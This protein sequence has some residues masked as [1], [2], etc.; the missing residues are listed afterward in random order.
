MDGKYQIRTGNGKRLQWNASWFLSM[1]ERFI[2]GEA[3]GDEVP[4]L[5]D[6]QGAPLEFQIIR[7][8]LTINVVGHHFATLLRICP[9]VPVFGTLYAAMVMRDAYLVIHALSLLSVAQRAA[10]VPATSSATW[11]AEPC[12]WG[13]LWM[14]V[15][16]TYWPRLVHVGLGDLGNLLGRVFANCDL[17]RAHEITFYE[18]WTHANP[19]QSVLDNICASRLA[20]MP[21]VSPR[22][23]HEWMKQLQFQM[24][25]EAR[26]RILLVDRSIG[27]H[28]SDADIPSR[29]ATGYGVDSALLDMLWAP[30]NFPAYC[31]FWHR[32]SGPCCRVGAAP[33]T[34]PSL[35]RC[36]EFCCRSRCWGCMRNGSFWQA[37]PTCS[38]LRP[39][40]EMTGSSLVLRCKEFGVY[41]G[42][43]LRSTAI[44]LTRTGSRQMVYGFDSFQGLVE[45]W[46]DFTAFEFS[47]NGQL[48]DLPQNAKL[49]VGWYNETL[50]RFVKEYMVETKRVIEWLHLDC[51]TFLGHHQVCFDQ[52][53]L[54]RKP[55]LV[56]G[57]T[58]IFDDILNYPG[59]EDH[60]LRAFYN[61]I[62]ESQCGIRWEDTGWSF[63]VLSSPWKVDWKISSRDSAHPWWLVRMRAL[64]VRLVSA[65]GKGS[66]RR[67]CDERNSCSSAMTNID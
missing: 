54:I 6:S 48:P 12:R 1:F 21:Y 23:F 58:L 7:S 19:M 43:T 50:P 45:A 49:V 13:V 30:T 62:Q 52:A 44:H 53:A 46:S 67:C 26:P 2:L 29:V 63:E 14:S 20:L 5:Q 47:T 66:F 38:N 24:H 61:F 15:V 28:P 34:F 56:P 3:C 40:L 41:W 27:A 32:E 42:A 55:Y 11:L 57:S 65:R 35:E 9:L 60:A 59:Y 8:L 37:L 16:D 10:H 25:V 17:R 31:H 51:D 33:A 39:D 36:E 18:A 22:P 4:C 64:S